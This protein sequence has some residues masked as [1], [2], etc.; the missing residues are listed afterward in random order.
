M[1]ADLRKMADCYRKQYGDDTDALFFAMQKSRDKLALVNPFLE[2]KNLVSL[3]APEEIVTIHGVKFYR[4]FKDTKPMLI[5]GVF[6]HYFLDSSSIMPPLLLP[7]PEG[8]EVL[9]MCSAPGG[10]LLV[11]I[12]RMISSVRFLA[13]DLSSARTYRL[14]NVLSEFLP[15]AMR[16]HLVSTTTK[17]AVYFGLR[18]P[19]RFDAVLLD[20]PC[21]SEA[22]VVH[23]AKRLKDFHGLNKALPRRQYSL[24][25]AAL[26]AL[27]P[28]GHVMYSTC[29]I[30]KDENDGVIKR[31]LHR[32]ADMASLI[33]ITSPLG[34]K[35]DYGI[36][37][38]PHLH[39]AGPAYF[40]LLRRHG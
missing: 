27:K 21:S 18:H 7:I 33:D 24:L 25:S 17:D 26:L 19:S 1:E 6:S 11:M 4:L 14:K 10:K 3:L 13:N 28:G 29:S 20:A 36:A 34:D 15:A 32:K 40:S 2:E 16:N 22:H 31:V 39:A 8:G 38:Y 30:N 37:I 5:D 9:D 12:S 23:D 35:T